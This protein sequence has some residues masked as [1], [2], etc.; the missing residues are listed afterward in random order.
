M[1]E[2]D[3]FLQ[4]YTYQNRFEIENTNNPTKQLQ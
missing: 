1:D 4:K 3:N 2:M